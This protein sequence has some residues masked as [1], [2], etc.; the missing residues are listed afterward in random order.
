MVAN[1]DDPVKRIA[2]VL[3]DT[4]RQQV[5]RRHM[6]TQ[7]ALFGAEQFMAGLRA[8]VENFLCE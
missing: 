4:Q 8:V 7:G 3:Q 6:Q 2:A 1:V 5:L